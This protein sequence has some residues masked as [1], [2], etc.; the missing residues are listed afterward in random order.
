M[1]RK[2]TTT[3]ADHRAAIERATRTDGNYRV[4]LSRMADR[5]AGR[6]RQLT[7]KEV[8]AKYDYFRSVTGEGR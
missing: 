8:A 3:T 7:T 1:P 2:R 6:T 4:L 5:A